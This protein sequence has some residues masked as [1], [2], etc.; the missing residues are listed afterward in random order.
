MQC[1]PEM[2]ARR[3]AAADVF[4]EFLLAEMTKEE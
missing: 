1:T 3:C 4:M 2:R